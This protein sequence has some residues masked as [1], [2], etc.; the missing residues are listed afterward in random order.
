MMAEKMPRHESSMARVGSRCSV[1]AGAIYIIS[2]AAYFA[3][4]VGRFDWNSIRSISEYFSQVPSAWPLWIIVNA[5][6]AIASLLAVG[7]VQALSDEM[8]PA[9]EGL[10]RWT[11][12]LAIIGYA[13]M[14]VSNL[15]DLYQIRHVTSAYLHLDASAQSAVEAIGRVSLDP[16][17]S[18]RFLTI[19]PWFL[20]A[21]WLA[22]RHGRLPRAV[23]VLGVFGGVA[24]L[25]FRRRIRSPA[26]DRNRDW[27]YSGPE[28]TGPCGCVADRAPRTSRRLR[29]P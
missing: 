6:A 24:A 26:F 13:I 9:Q 11:S 19:G 8:R 29:I 20:V 3:S 23:A 22:L 16:A 10:V 1:L 21:G 28:G 18:L 7:G 4:Q 17:M 27:C 15:A 14:A 12:T 25:A 2:G 5:G